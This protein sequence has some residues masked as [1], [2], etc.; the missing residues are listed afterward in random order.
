MLLAIRAIAA[1]RRFITPS[2]A[3]LLADA[4]QVPDQ[5]APHPLL[6][7]RQFQV[8]LQLAQGARVEEIAD[9]VSLSEKQVYTHRRVLTREMHLHTSS[10]LTYNALKHGILG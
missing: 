1:G 5:P 4:L 7:R 2:V 8:F 9:S 10:D 6:T 3:T